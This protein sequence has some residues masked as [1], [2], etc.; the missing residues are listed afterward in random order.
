M[1]TVIAILIALALGSV[2]AFQGTKTFF[3]WKTRGKSLR[4]RAKDEDEE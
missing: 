3:A 4:P 2:I 1:N